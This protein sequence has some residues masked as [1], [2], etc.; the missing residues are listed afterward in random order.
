MCV[1][2]LYSKAEACVVHGSDLRDMTPAD[3]DDI[4]HSHSEMILCIKVDLD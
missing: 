1:C 4:L 3:I 2:L